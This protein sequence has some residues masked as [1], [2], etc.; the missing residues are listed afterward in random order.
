MTS[1]SCSGIRFRYDRTRTVFF[2]LGR[3]KITSDFFFFASVRLSRP[4]LHIYLSNKETVEDGYSWWSSDCPFHCSWLS[5]FCLLLVRWS[6]VSLSSINLGN[7]SKEGNERRLDENSQFYKR[8]HDYRTNIQNFRSPR[9][10]NVIS[11]LIV[12]HA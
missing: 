9:S 6:K 4:L 3:Q 7:A 8:H 5:I 2:D 12:S 10:H 1:Y 11:F